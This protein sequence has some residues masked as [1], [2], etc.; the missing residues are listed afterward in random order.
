MEEV[1]IGG[2]YRWLLSHFSKKDYLTVNSV[3][4]VGSCDAMDA[5]WLQDV[6]KAQVHA[7]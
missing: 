2:N 1:H 3:V 6:I 4:E 7:F 5:I